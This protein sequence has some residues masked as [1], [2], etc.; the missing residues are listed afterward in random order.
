MIIQGIEGMPSSEAQNV[1]AILVA[2]NNTPLTDRLTTVLDEVFSLELTTSASALDTLLSQSNPHIVMLDPALFNDTLKETITAAINQAT[3]T[4]IIILEDD[5]NMPVDQLG[6]F[7]TGV[8]GFLSHTIT[9][10]LLL[11]AT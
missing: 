11:K 1:P 4:R 5:E 3:Q 9:S 2:S 8:Q 10:T 7:K 6:L